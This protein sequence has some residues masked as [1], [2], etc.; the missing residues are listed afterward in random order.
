MLFRSPRLHLPDDP[1]LDVELVA[2]AAAGAGV[3]TWIVGEV[4]AWA[5]GVR[6]AER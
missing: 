4:Q 5:T 6:F 3:E 1:G 2:A